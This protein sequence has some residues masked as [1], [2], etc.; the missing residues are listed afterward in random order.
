MKQAE[1][2][3]CSDNGPITYIIRSE[4]PL[5]WE[6]EVCPSWSRSLPNLLPHLCRN[7][8]T[9]KEST[10]GVP[11][12]GLT[13]FR[14]PASQKSVQAKPGCHLLNSILNLSGL[15]SRFLL[16]NQVLPKKWTAAAFLRLAP[17][18]S[19]VH[20]NEPFKVLFY[21]WVETGQIPFHIYPKQFQHFNLLEY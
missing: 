15:P 10:E 4:T 13:S 9:H 6:W 3:I 16:G 21:F 1:S 14:F 2:P 7:T 11:K 20:I 19:P 8:Q 17:Y 12:S 5:L 18:P